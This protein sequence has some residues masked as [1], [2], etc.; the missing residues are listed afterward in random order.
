MKSQKSLWQPN[1]QVF[2]F[3]D[4]EGFSLL[5]KEKDEN[6]FISLPKIRMTNG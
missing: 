6:M 4:S 3:K 2:S 1:M 5:K